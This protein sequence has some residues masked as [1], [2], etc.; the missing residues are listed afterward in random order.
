MF[1]KLKIIVAR[2]YPFFRAQYLSNNDHHKVKVM[3]N[4]RTFNVA[5]SLGVERM[6]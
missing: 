6:L 2:L 5:L 3:L 4:E 1:K